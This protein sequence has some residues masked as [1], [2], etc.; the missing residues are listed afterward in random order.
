MTIF[1]N[2]TDIETDD[3]FRWRAED[4]LGELC[5]DL[6]G[7]SRY[8]Y[9]LDPEDENDAI[10]I[11]L[12]GMYAFTTKG[13]NLLRRTQDRLSSLYVKHFGKEGEYLDPIEIPGLIEE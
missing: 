10:L 7:D 5:Q 12:G 13:M 1:K 11:D 8:S 2:H 9:E 6:M 4:I 3:D